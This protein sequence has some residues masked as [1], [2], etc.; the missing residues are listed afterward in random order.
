MRAP[1]FHRPQIAVIALTL[2][3]SLVAPGC[4]GDAEASSPP[5]ESAAPVDSAPVES[6]DAT[7]AGALR[8]AGSL[9]YDPRQSLAPLVKSVAP[10]VVSIRASRSSGGIFSRQTQGSG[11]GFVFASDGVIVTNHHVVDGARQL[12]VTLHDGTHYPAEV[13]GSDAAT[14]LAVLRLQG[15]HDLPVLS[16]GDSAELEV[17]DWVVAIGNPMGLDHSASVGILSGRGRG[18]LGLY[19]D[20]YLDFLQTDADIAPGSSGGPLFDLAG[21]VVGITTAVGANSRPG[22]AIPAAQARQVIPQLLATGKVSRGWLGAGSGRRGAEARGAVIGEVFA[23]TP[24]AEAGLQAGDVV[25]EVDRQRIDDFD[26]LRAVI[27]TLGPGHTVLMKV[28]RDGRSLEL[29]AVLGARPPADDLD[30]I[31]R[32]PA[33]RSPAPPQAPAMSKSPTFG[34]RLGVGARRHDDGLQVVRVEPGSL[35][36]DL[37][38]RA[39]DIVTTINGTTVEAPE[40]V[41]DALERSRDRVEI[42]LLRDGVKHNVSL[43]RS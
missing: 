2:G 7:P 42:Q 25:V 24:A 29:T 32:V 15:T 14:D 22:F 5:P 10:S 17:G 8:Q 21:N 33:P 1:S 4:G 43:E 6:D 16:L 12:E 9:Q 37:D 39:G 11:S 34:G 27:G 3:G 20:S 40:D 38:L 31:R 41:Q 36:D 28:E 26:S 19:A 23:D 30:D 18:S 35:A 13:L